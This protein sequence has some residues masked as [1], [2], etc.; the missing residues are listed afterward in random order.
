MFLKAE[1]EETVK[2]Y[3]VCSGENQ[4]SSV[5]SALQTHLRTKKKLYFFTHQMD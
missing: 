3:Q 2:A 4:H 5:A 1:G